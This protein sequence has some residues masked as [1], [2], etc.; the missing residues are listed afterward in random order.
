MTGYELRERGIH[1]C[2][3]ENAV[4]VEQLEEARKKEPRNATLKV[5]LLTAQKRL[6]N[7]KSE[8]AV[9][10]IVKNRSL[11]LFKSKCPSIKE[12]KA[13]K[14]ITRYFCFMFRAL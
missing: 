9:E 13:Y 2:I 5:D 11:N 3:D 12:A 1:K 7:M 6:S 8:V 4:N 10:T 14:G